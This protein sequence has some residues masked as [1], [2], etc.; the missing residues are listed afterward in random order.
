MRIDKLQIALRPRPAAQAL[1]LGFALLHA[2]AGNVYR[3]WLA[4][5]LPAV[6]LA[7]LLSLWLPEQA[8]LWLFLPWWL[9]PLLERAPLYVLSRQV[10]GESVGWRQALRAW[11]GQLGGGAVRMLTWWRPF[12]AGRGLYQPVWQLENARGK[13]AAERRAILARGGT[14]R[15]AYGFGL[16]CAHFELVLQIGLMALI[17]FFLSDGPNV[18]PFSWLFAERTAGAHWPGLL[19]PLLCLGMAGAIT[20]PI[21]TACC[22]TL[23]LNRRATLEAWD[24]ELTLR[25]IQAPA[26]RKGAQSGR[27]LPAL[28]APLAAAALAALLSLPAMPG[29]AA[30][31]PPQAE[32]APPDTI[33]EALRAARP[34]ARD[35]AQQRLRGELRQLYDSEELRAYVCE[36]VWRLKNPGKPSPRPAPVKMPDLNLVAQIVKVLLIATAIAVLGWLLYRY[37]DR[38]PSFAKAGAAQRATEIG[39]LDIRAD[40]LPADVAATVLRLWD[41]GELRAAL[42]LLYRATLS[43]LV[44]QD[45]LLLTQGATEGDCLRLALQAVQREQLSRARYDVAD[46]ATALWLNGAYGN[47]WP[48]SAAVHAACEAWQAQ[49]AQLPEPAQ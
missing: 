22:F 3:T 2:H 25:Q 40:S 47:R 19:F 16:A 5:W 15:A 34:P 46:T 11:P 27:A 17:G 45:G 37:R 26:P 12:M 23:Y 8:T 14:G 28:C 21:Y 7:A 39:G 18:N 44:Q 4:V 10:F 24:I 48:P 32:C 13:V 30:D 20:G 41:A 49:F 31:T 1:D 29:R 33:K 36:P 9:R 6:A 43:R 35:D 42:A 38:F